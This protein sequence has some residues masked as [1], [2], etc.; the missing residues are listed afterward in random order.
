[1]FKRAEAEIQNV[2]SIIEGLNDFYT[3]CT[4]TTVDPKL[5]E[6]FVNLDGVMNNNMHFLQDTQQ[7]GK[8]NADATTEG[9]SVLVIGYL[10]CY[11]GTGD[12]KYL[13]L[14][15]WYWEAYKEWWYRHQPIP[16]TPQ[17]WICNWIINGKEPVLANYPLDLKNPTHGGFKGVEFTWT[18]GMTKIPHGAPHWGEYLD[19]ATFAFDGA[20]SYDSIKASV[21][22][23]LP[24][25]STDWDNDGKQYDV[26]WVILWNRKK[27]NWDGDVISE[28]HTLDEVGTVQL[29]DTT[30]NGVHKFNYATRNPV[31][32]GGYMIDRNEPF[33][34]RPIQTPLG[35]NPKNMGNAADG[36]VWFLDACYLMWKVTG[37]EKYK[38]ALD[39]VHFT[40]NEYTYIDATNKFFR[41][42]TLANTPFTEGISY[43]YTFPSD[44]EVRFSRDDNGYIKAVP[45]SACDTTFEQQAVVFR[46]DTNSKLRTTYGGAN[47]D[48][49]PIQAEVEIYISDDK[50]SDG[51]AYTASMPV[52]KDVGIEEI[53]I[54]LTNFVRSEKDDGSKYMLASES[55]TTDYGDAIVTEKFE[56]GITG[57]TLDAGVRNSNIIETTFPTDGG[58]LIIGFWLNKSETADVKS[59]VYRS[60][61]ETKLS[62]DDDDKWA[63]HWVLPNTRGKWTQITL[64]R[65]DLILNSYQADHPKE[66]PR[67]TAPNYTEVK[68]VSVSLTNAETNKTFAYYC[69]NDMPPAFTADDAYVVRYA[70]TADSNQTYELLVGDCDIRDPRDDFLDYCPGLI[71]FSNIYEPD[72]NE[73]GPWHG[74]PYPGYQAPSM[75]CL[76]LGTDDQALRLKNSIDF[77]YDSQQW[78]HKEFGVLGP[79]AQAYIWDRWDAIEYGTPGNFTN[80][81]WGTGKA[82]SG[83]QPR[84]FSWMCR[85]WQQLHDNGEEIPP[86]LQAYCENWMTYLWGFANRDDN[87]QHWFPYDFPQFHAPIPEDDFNASM[88]G[89]Y[90]SGCAL[91]GIAGCKLP[92]LDDLIDMLIVEFERN[93]TVLEDKPDNKMNGSYTDWYGGNFFYGFHGA[94]AFKGLGAYLMYKK[95]KAKEDESAP[96]EY[97]GVVEPGT[98]PDVEVGVKDENGKTKPNRPV[99]EPDWTENPTKPDEPSPP[100]GEDKVYEVDT[101]WE[102][103]EGSYIVN[104]RNEEFVDMT[105]PPT[106]SDGTTTYTAT[107]APFKVDEGPY[108]GTNFLFTAPSMLK[109]PFTFKF[110]STDG[111]TYSKQMVQTETEYGYAQTAGDT[112][113]FR[114]YRLY[115][116]DINNKPYVNPDSSKAI[117]TDGTN[118]LEAITIEPY[119]RDYVQLK[120]P[121]TA[122]IHHPFTIKINTNTSDVVVG[123]S[124]GI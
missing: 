86:K 100:T 29:K 26:D 50:S 83:Y 34:N 18:N 116:T 2:K 11:L 69:V 68:Q 93:Y 51:Y 61:A 80:N 124:R 48:G 106:I 52:K 72:S 46:V 8:P 85:T 92:F 16:D 94:E 15:E 64:N 24:D 23:L 78:Y 58:G 60:D 82:W 90:L 95:H 73:I 74:L 108:T 55:A 87:P 113:E 67:P 59:I 19:V 70:I 102:H 71:P 81:H 122:S 49:S 110:K 101:I 20:L 109:V 17:R 123:N 43:Y 28:N 96:T 22:A 98:T 33:H 57:P 121:N 4:G 7:E 1:M 103:S 27:V 10:Y 13:E 117:V 56:S 9:Q 3:R 38:K 91:A 99:G 119:F 6:Y 37:K 105:T 107:E 77:M 30:V 76:G 104:T 25:G 62:L 75:Y 41:R 31:E 114:W 5:E 97:E 40:A 12:K 66:A 63:W 111:N 47:A 14:A 79:G 45:E 88:G 32:H 36:E 21:K 65:A 39:S 89:L 120:V 42:D 118:T 35:D 84:A 44:I 54:P 112:P 115:Y 53:L